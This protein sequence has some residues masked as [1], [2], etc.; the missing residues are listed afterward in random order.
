MG[1]RVLLVDDDTELVSLLEQYLAKEGFDVEAVHSGTEG[2]VRAREADADVVVLDVMLPGMNG[3]DVLRELRLTSQVP[4][5]MLSA[6]G[7]DVD[8]IVG[9][10]M[11]ADDYLPKPF[12]PRELSARLRALVRRADTAP[13]DSSP[14]EVIASGDLS[15]DLS[16][17]V[18]RRGDDRI[19]LTDVEFSL[20]ELL[21]RAP[22]QV[23]TRETISKVALGRRLSPLDRSIDVHVSNLRKKLGPGPGG[24]PRIK[25]VRSAGYVLVAPER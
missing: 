13:R 25:T 24:R 7:E 9:L 5:L 4:V 23:V 3:F 15:M 21:L 12:N 22:G 1:S 16:A 10:E 18:V 19:D 17:W 11:G 20:L 6:R 8:R 14:R 2:L